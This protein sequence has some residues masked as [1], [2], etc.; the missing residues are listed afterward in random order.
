MSKKDTDKKL[1]RFSTI[2]E[3]ITNLGQIVTWILGVGSAYVLNIQTKP[4]VVPGIDITL[5]LG[6]QFAL[7][8]SA[9]LGYIHFLQKFWE[10]NVEKL[11]LSN[12]F[13]D[14]SLWDLPRLRQPLLL[15]P[16]VIAVA[17]FIQVSIK[18]Y[19]LVAIFIS[20]LLLIGYFSYLRFK[21]HLSPARRHEKLIQNWKQNDVW[22][23]KW[24]KRIK[25]VLELY[26]AVRTRDLYKAG[27]NYNDEDTLEIEMALYTYFQKYEFE[28]DLVLLRLNELNYNHPYHSYTSSEYVLMPREKLKLRNPEK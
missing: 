1:G 27:M 13:I 18:S 8:I 26:I 17:I 14:F 19:W 7:L 5:D 28:E 10:K 20:I 12:T 24:S 15:I 21:Y 23:D 25:K 3:I 9:M 22:F 16:I 11:K 2:L 6:F 4:I